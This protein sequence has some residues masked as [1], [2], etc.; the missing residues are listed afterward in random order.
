MA[1][2]TVS[3]ADGLALFDSASFGAALDAAPAGSTH[4]LLRNG[5]YNIWSDQPFVVHL[6]DAAN[7][8]GALP[9]TQ[10]AVGDYPGAAV[11][12]LAIF[13]FQM[14]DEVTVTV[15]GTPGITPT[16]IR[17]WTLGGAGTFYVSN[18]FRRTL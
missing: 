4:Y 11:P 17:V 5:L 10:G 2:G 3:E 12:Q 16:G 1:T 8:P 7:D 9:G 18:L 14:D 13:Q 6:T 15:N